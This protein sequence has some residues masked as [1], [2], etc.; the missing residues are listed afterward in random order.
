[1]TEIFYLKE[2]FHL[3]SGE[4][5]PSLHLA[6]TTYGWLNESRDNVVWVFH[7]LTAN[8]DPAEWW[9]G[10]VGQGKLI[11]PAKYFIV[12]VNM[13]GSCYGSIGPLSKDPDT[14]ESYFHAFPF[15]TTRDMVKAYQRLRYALGIRR[16]K[17]GIGGSMG[18]QQLLEWAIEE[19]R[20]FEHIV[21]IATNAF[22]SAWG[23]AFN[24]SQR[25]CIEVDATWTDRGRW[26]G[27]EGMK[28]ARG[29]GLLSYRNYH[30]YD[31]HQREDD[32][33]KLTDFK[34]SSYQVYQGEKLARRFNAFS[35]HTLT[36]SMDAHNVGRGRLSVA[37]A[38]NTIQAHTLV[39]GIG[40]DILFPLSE[41]QYIAAHINNARFVAIHSN[42]GHDG[43][44]LENDS[45]T[46]IIG[47]FVEEAFIST[48]SV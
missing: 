19:P 26:A 47:P 16:I 40:T 4:V 27:I 20:L 13:P 24:E 34:S 35:Y 18:G 41:Q 23:I 29:L 11:D 5:L 8:S 7:A 12:C 30:I 43:F 1:M 45:L 38:L 32:R 33:R 22:H 9:P 42:Y 44:L 39:I 3:E 21:P 15:F 37:A 48:S 28:V 31:I 17:L 2:P 25:R 6:Y 10:L 14:G 36:R 46:R